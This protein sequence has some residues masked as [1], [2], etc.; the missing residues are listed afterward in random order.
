MLTNSISKLPTNN[1]T[2]SDIR[3]TA[4]VNRMV[5]SRVGQVTFRSSAATSEKNFAGAILG[6]LGAFGFSINAIIKETS[7]DVQIRLVVYIHAAE[8]SLW[9][10][11]E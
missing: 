8:W 10:I 9:R 11:V 6:M 1:P 7:A 2:A 5:S 3:M 4:V